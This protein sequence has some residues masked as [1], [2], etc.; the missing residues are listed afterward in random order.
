[1]NKIAVLDKDHINYRPFIN[2]FRERI[3]DI[4][5]RYVYCCN[6][7][8]PKDTEVKNLKDCES[9][10]GKW[11]SVFFSMMFFLLSKTK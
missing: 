1:M 4:Q 3:C 9:P 10:K 11:S 7:N 6:D 2:F 5:T 8:W